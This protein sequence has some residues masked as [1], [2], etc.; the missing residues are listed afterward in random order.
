MNKRI[1]VLLLKLWPP[2]RVP[3]LEEELRRCRERILELEENRPPGANQWRLAGLR[4]A[5]RETSS[6]RKR[7]EL[8]RGASR[9]AELEQVAAIFREGLAQENKRLALAAGEA[10][11]A[12][13]MAPCGCS[14][15]FRCSRCKALDALRPHVTPSPAQGDEGQTDTSSPA[16]R[17]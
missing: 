16:P 15:G 4:A 13:L 9:E 11:A 1:H 5:Q 10:E 6:L 17:D 8:L 14:G 2:L 3:H 7:V 12:L